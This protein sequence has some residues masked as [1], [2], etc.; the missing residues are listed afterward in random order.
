MTLINNERPR[1]IAAIDMGSNSF[2]MVVARVVGQSLQIISRH[3]QRVHLASGLDSQ[4]NL[5]Q[6]AIQRGLNCLTMFAERLQGFAPENVRIAATYTL[7]Q[8]RNAHVFLKRAENIMPYPIEIIPGTEE[9]RLIYLGVA[10]TQPN[11]GRKLIVDIGGGSTELVIGEEFDTHVLYS[12]HMGCVSYNKNH[13]QNAKLNSK[14]FAEA[15]LAAQQK[16]E[17]IT[18]KYRKFGWDKAVGSS[19]TIKAIREVLIANGYSDGVITSKRLNQLIEQVLSFKTTEDLV[20]LG[21]TDDR[22]PV[23]AAGLAILSAVFSAL[24]IDEMIYSDGALREGLLYE[25]EDRFRHSDIRTRTAN[26]MAKQ[27]NID[28]DQANRVQHT[29]EYFYDQ[30]DTHP[31]LAKSELS[32]LLSWGALLHEVGLSI[33]YPGFHRH[34]AYLL[35]HSTMPGFNLEQQ[36]V[37]ATLVRFQRKAL[38]LEEMPELSI[39]KRKHLYPLI[40]TLRIATAL[41]GQRIDDPL[42]NIKIKAEKEHWQLMLPVGWLSS[43]KLLAAD[44]IKEQEYWQKAGWQLSIAEEQ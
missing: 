33:S 42:P 14:N 38:K 4:Q 3:K 35:R 11:A 9:A 32:I 22:K 21:L 17:S 23:F 41:N 29:A 39:Y 19:G 34:S 15:Q 24:N 12:K 16:M 27:Y 37:L 5:D 8:A 28:I 26:A 40:R 18:S 7:R 6:A 30:I 10:H 36:T 31:G 43:N 25:M 44:L 20:L 13:F 2:H 1:E